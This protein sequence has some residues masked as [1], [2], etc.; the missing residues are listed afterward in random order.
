MK[1]KL[2]SASVAMALAMTATAAS[3]VDFHG[4][5]RS[6]VGVSNDG[7]LQTYQKQMV[8][9]LGNEDDTYAELA[10]GAEL[11]NEDNK[12]LYFASLVSME[13]N[14]STDSETTKNDDAVFGLREVNIQAK[15]YISALPDAVAWVGKRFYQRHD[16]HIIDTKY[17][18]ISGAGAGV[19]NIKAGEGAFSIAWIRGD[20]DDLEANI[21]DGVRDDLNINYLDL[22]YAGI[23]PWDGAWGEVGIT[24]AMPNATDAQKEYGGLYDADNGLMLT[25]EMS[26]FFSGT[27]INEK[28]VLQ[29]ADK[30]MAQNMVSQG[31]GWYDAWNNTT[32]AKGYRVIL[33]GDIPLGE[34][35]LIDH[36]ITY[37]KG[38][39]LED[40]H[41]NTELFSAV[42]R[43]QYVWNKSTKTV[44]E[45][46]TFDST[47]TWT[48]G[49]EDKSS[50]QKYTLAQVWTAGIPFFSRPE[51]RAYV[52][53]LKN[54][55]AASF[56]DGSKDNAVNFGLQ[57]EAW[58]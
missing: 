19:E 36:V 53:Y 52:S 39:K 6:G 54:G 50:G 17:W 24:Y 35:V 23:K 14:G 41:D 47:L 15:G 22:R 49:S 11:F 8:G 44:M 4:Y 5:F 40:W 32:D 29:Y 10:F 25:A 20:A 58:W 27:G 31:G 16:L 7:G 57:A 33:A 51:V 37:G 45:L 43:G 28:L 56:N 55:E 9:R 48:S 42:A 13:S 1:A 30:G 21:P 3:A 2:L 34:K 26:Q 12:S 46:G 38:E 18:N